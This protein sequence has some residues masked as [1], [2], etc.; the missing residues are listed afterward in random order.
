M[1]VFKEVVLRI[2]KTIDNNRIFSLNEQVPKS[3]MAQVLTT[4]FL[5]RKKNV[6][7]K[8]PFQVHAFQVKKQKKHL[9]TP[10]RRRRIRTLRWSDIREAF[11]L[12]VFGQKFDALPPA[13]FIN[14]NSIK[15]AIQLLKKWYSHVV[16]MYCR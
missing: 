11:D 1:N 8:T 12:G 14:L 16:T 15:T 3:L 5:P 2:T 13:I 7:K 6:K 4:T 10:G 9:K